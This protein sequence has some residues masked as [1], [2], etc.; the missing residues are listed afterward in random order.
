MELEL[1][2]AAFLATHLCPAYNKVVSLLNQ[3]VTQWPKGSAML[4]GYKGI[5]TI[6]VWDKK[7][8]EK[9]LGQKVKYFYE[10][11]KSTKSV[12]VTIKVKPTFQ[13]YVN[14][15]YIT[16]TGF[17]RS[18]AELL[19]NEKIDSILGQFGKV[20]VPTQDVFAESFLTGKKKLR[21]DLNK[22]KDIPRDFHVLVDTPGGKTLTATLR[23]YYRDQPWHC[24]RCTEQHTGDCPKYIAEKEEKQQ[25]KKV[26]ENNTSTILIGDSN[27]RCV[28][29]NGVMASVTAVT[30]G[31]LGHIINQ[32][33]FEDLSKT[34]T[35]ILSA[36][37]N[38]INDADEVEEKC[39][40]ARTTGE[41]SK[42]EKLVSE[43]MD[44]GKNVIFLSVPPAPCTQTSERKIRARN[45]INTHIAKL[46]ERA[47]SLDNKT[48]TAGCVGEA[49]TS[50]DTST[51]FQD[52]R[53]LT[54]RAM[55]RR[56]S[57]LDDILPSNRKLRNP[58]TL[59]ARPTCDPYRSCY[60]A[61]PAG[62]MYCTKLKHSEEECPMRKK[63]GLKRS[64]VS[65]S[66]IQDPKSQRTG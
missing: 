17:D 14:P 26:K 33:Q 3:T 55:E 59:T 41:I 21:L 45:F 51:D 57:L 31:K 49:D 53:H 65:G 27:F 8:G 12:T 9:L 48:G 66:D 18:P 6:K 52:E 58:T 13:R 50:Y 32:A 19:T 40:E 42:T 54:Q 5:Y 10:G 43:L 61:Y 44:K 35:I 7:K 25:L 38:C 46:V 39:W 2:F 16:I 22:E 56:I 11:D 34:D 4:T 29:E 24:K 47:N 23:L 30:G 28:N 64:V 1:N 37:Q 63:Q 20:I 60:G 15:K 62:C 36:G